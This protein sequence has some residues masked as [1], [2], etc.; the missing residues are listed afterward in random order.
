[1]KKQGTAAA[2]ILG[3]LISFVIYLLFQLLLAAVAVRIMIPERH[4]TGLQIATC[5]IAV[6]CGGRWAVGHT[7]FGTLIASLIVTCGVIVIMILSGLAIYDEINWTGKSGGLLLGAVCGGVLAG[8][9]G[10]KKRSTG[11]K[12]KR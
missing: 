4:L 9:L 12:R 5:V 6:F 2:L 10:R 8:L 1:M 7:H 3:L 11:K